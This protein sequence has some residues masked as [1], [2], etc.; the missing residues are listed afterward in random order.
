MRALCLGL[1]LIAS[2]ALAQQTPL[3]AKKEEPARAG[4]A[5]VVEVNPNEFMPSKCE[6]G[7][8]VMSGSRRGACIGGQR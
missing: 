6:T 1:M 5:R 7:F 3:D 8:E 2:P 4:M